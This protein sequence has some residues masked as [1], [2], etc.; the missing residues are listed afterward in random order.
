M[1]AVYRNVEVPVLGKLFTK[2][3]T[4][5]FWITWSLAH[6]TLEQSNTRGRI[7]KKTDFPYPVGSAAKTFRTQ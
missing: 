1:R 7:A 5:L 2:T 3:W 6:V 4:C